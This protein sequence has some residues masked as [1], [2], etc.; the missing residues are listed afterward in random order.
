MNPGEVFG[1]V[2]IGM[3]LLIISV[4]IP[5]VR[6][7]IPMNS[8]YGVRIRKSFESDENWYAINEYGGKQLIIWS[9]PMLLAGVACFFIPFEEHNRDLMALAAGVLPVMTCMTGS[10]IRIMSYAKKL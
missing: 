8:L 2:N 7:R 6:R 1:L 4:S 9:V 10:L 3:A 5:L